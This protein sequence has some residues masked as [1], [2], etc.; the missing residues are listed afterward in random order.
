MAEIRLGAVRGSDPV[1]WVECNPPFGRA[2]QTCGHSVH[3]Y[4]KVD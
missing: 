2:R 1:K 3:I 4:Q